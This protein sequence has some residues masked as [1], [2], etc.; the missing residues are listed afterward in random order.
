MPH[1]LELP[2]MWSAV[3]KLVC[4][5]RLAGFLRRVVNKFITLAH[6]HSFGRGRRRS[7]GRPRLE[8]G[9]AAIVRALNDLTKPAAGLRRE[10]AVRVHTRTLHVVNLPSG[11]VRPTNVPL[12]TLSI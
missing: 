12:F 3:I 9:L 11:K 10:D 6:R 1:S 8:P 7:G 5:E 2:R 4:R